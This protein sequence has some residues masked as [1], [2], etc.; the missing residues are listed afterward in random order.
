MNH[1]YYLCLLSPTFVLFCEYSWYD[2]WMSPTQ[3]TTLATAQAMVSN[4]LYAAGF[5]FVNLD[6]GNMIGEPAIKIKR[7]DVGTGASIEACNLQAATL[8]ARSIPTPLTFRKEWPTWRHSC[9]PWGWDSGFTLIEGRRH[10]EGARASLVMR[11]WMPT[12]MPRGG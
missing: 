5:R 7:G 11:S 10:V 3:E 2:L 4:G 12:P 9:T 6:D 1:A 8:T